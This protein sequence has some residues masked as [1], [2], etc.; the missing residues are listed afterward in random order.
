MQFHRRPGWAELRVEPDIAI[1]GA[2][3]ILRVDDLPCLGEDFAQV[4]RFTPARVADNHV[5]LE[6]LLLQAHGGTRRSLRPDQVRLR[7]NRFVEDR[8]GARPPRVP[9]LDRYA[10]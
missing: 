5:G 4:E 10:G 7:T 6:P 9:P 8:R 3:V 1:G 2:V